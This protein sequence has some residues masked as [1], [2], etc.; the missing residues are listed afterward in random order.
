VQ[1]T[2]RCQKKNGLRLWTARSQRAIERSFS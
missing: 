1:R 2:N